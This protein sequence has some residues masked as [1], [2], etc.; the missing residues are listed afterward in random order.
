MMMNSGSEQQ[1][2][3]TKSKQS[4]AAQIESNNGKLLAEISNVLDEM[5]DG[6][7]LV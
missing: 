4:R 2:I 6:V 3:L 1:H 7:G 5:L